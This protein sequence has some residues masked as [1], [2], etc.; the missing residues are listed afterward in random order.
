MALQAIEE[1]SRFQLAL[2]ER[3]AT[4]A[5]EDAFMESIRMSHFKPR[6]R[7]KSEDEQLAAMG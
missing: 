5:L 7:Q 6:V 2:Q 3:A 1:K 4:A